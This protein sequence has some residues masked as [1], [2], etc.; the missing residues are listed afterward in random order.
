MMN[1]L[2]ED[3]KGIDIRMYMLTFLAYV[4]RI[5]KFESVGVARV[6]GTENVIVGNRLLDAL[7]GHMSVYN[8]RMNVN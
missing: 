3:E 4:G 6:Q 1:W 2:L 8:I 7:T 5:C